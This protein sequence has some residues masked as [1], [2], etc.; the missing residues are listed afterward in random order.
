MLNHSIADFFY[1]PRR[2][3]S[4]SSTHILYK[5]KQNYQNP[6]HQTVREL[7]AHTAYR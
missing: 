5:Y 1:L 2:V 6:L 4:D 7:L 3:E